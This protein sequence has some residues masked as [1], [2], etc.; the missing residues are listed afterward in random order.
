MNGPVD[1][2]IHIVLSSALLGG[3]NS[4]LHVTAALPSVKE[5]S[6]STI[7]ETGWTPERTSEKTKLLTL[8]GLELRNLRR[9]TSN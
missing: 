2:Q 7:Y 4:Q 3:V 9:R 1:V 6:G 8:K 5:P